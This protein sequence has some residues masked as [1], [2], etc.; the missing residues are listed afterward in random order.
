LKAPFH[1]LP[2]P[3]SYTIRQAEKFGDS[4]VT[5]RTTFNSGLTPLPKLQNEFMDVN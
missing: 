1:L 4:D 2:T 3:V 5:G